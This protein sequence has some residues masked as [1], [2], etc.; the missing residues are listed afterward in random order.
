MS[1]LDRGIGA[2]DRAVVAFVTSGADWTGPHLEALRAAGAR[3][4][5]CSPDR[6]L[7]SILSALLYDVIVLA[8]VDGGVQGL[9]RA[10]EED[11]KLRTV[12][13]V[14]LLAPASGPS[15]E[16]ALPAIPGEDPLETIA[17]LEALV[18]GHPSRRSVLPSS[19]GGHSLRPVSLPPAD[20]AARREIEAGFHDI[21]V[22]L[23]VVVG[24]GANLRDGA[25]GP[26]TEMQR[27][28]VLKMVEAAADATAIL[29]HTMAAGR[30][31]AL[32]I[33]VGR[34][35]GTPRTHVDVSA[36]AH[37]LVGMFSKAA[38]QRSVTLACAAPEPVRVWGNTVQLKQVVAN[39]IVNALKFTPS[40]GRVRVVVRAAARG[41]A[42]IVVSDTGPGIPVQERARIFEHGV[43]LARDLGVGGTGVGL[44][45][46]REL[47]VGHHGG[48]V[49]VDEAEGGGAEFI[50]S[51][52]L[53]RRSCA[54]D[55]STPLRD[56]NPR[57]EHASAR[58]PPRDERVPLR[59]PS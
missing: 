11:G 49:R 45:V 53:D 19:A 38:A 9:A 44:A 20:S 6:S 51:L 55:S 48:S 54:R 17:T 18:Q 47:V 31:V 15:I 23:G 7:W 13:T 58:E 36:L 12:P 8:D 27:G 2:L 59:G 34:L 50:V 57:D 16:L 29:E 14:C 41:Q 5:V 43:R 33:P 56:P 37:S 35:P 4:R 3:V 42:E 40:R 26:L 25:D 10:L 30:A 1:A 39:L 46:V 28:H 52:P 32:G 22:L 21:R 24:Y